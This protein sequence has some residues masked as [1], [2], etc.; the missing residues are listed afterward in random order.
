MSHQPSTYFCLF[1]W[2]D[3]TTVDTG[4]GEEPSIYLELE[5]DKTTASH[6]IPMYC[7]DWTLT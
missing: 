3:Q 2:D 6:V 7:G 5:F 1:T 4:T